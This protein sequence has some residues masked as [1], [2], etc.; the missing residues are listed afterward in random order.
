MD[1][2]TE[3]RSLK[4]DKTTALHYDNLYYEVA[5]GL[6]AYIRPVNFYKRDREIYKKLRKGTLRSSDLLAIEYGHFPLNPHIQSRGTSRAGCACRR[7][8]RW[9][10]G[11][12]AA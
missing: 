9:H 10:P 4:F 1:Q 3:S 8:I 12:A 11:A 5:M 7:N 2:F 6:S